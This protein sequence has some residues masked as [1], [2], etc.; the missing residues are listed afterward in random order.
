M[1]KR[2]RKK[3]EGNNAMM[4]G[5]KRIQGRT[6]KGGKNARR[7][8]NENWKEKERRIVIKNKKRKKTTKSMK[9]RE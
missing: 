3:F 4:Q 5:G 6:T 8:E 7:K 2:E 9:I 1:T